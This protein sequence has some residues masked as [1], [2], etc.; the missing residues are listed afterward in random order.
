MKFKYTLATSNWIASILA[1]IVELKYC[2]VPCLFARF[3]LISYMCLMCSHQFN[4]HRKVLYLFITRTRVKNREQQLTC[5]I[6]LFHCPFIHI[7]HVQLIM[8]KW[9]NKTFF[10]WRHNGKSFWKTKTKTTPQQWGSVAKTR[11]FCN[12]K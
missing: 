8:Y 11:A 2:D 6:H 10:Y 4:A 5:Y 3:F 7:I 12:D 9:I 1:R